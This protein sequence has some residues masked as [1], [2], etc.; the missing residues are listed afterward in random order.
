MLQYIN[1]ASKN[2]NN[3]MAEKNSPVA[4]EKRTNKLSIFRDKLFDRNKFSES[5]SERKPGKLVEKTHHV[6][7][8]NERKL[9]DKKSPIFKS[10]RTKTPKLTVRRCLCNLENIVQVTKPEGN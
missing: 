9:L 3:K 10:E 5:E 1:V 7:G 4:V 8:E 2:N 6:E